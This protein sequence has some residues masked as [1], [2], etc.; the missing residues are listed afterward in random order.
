MPRSYGGYS[1]LRF[2]RH[3]HVRLKLN[4]L[5]CRKGRKEAALGLS[6]IQGDWREHGVPSQRQLRILENGLC[7]CLHI[8][9]ATSKASLSA[10]AKRL[11]RLM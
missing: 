9:V 3:Q 2:V 7:G 8:V 11:L 1:W 5:P 10:M 4:A 6:R